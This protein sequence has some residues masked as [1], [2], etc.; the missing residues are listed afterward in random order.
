MSRKRMTKTQSQRWHTK[1]NLRDRYGIFCNR[2]VYFYLLDSIKN[3]QSE[4][5]LKQSN[6]RYLYKVYL[7]LSECVD[8]RTRICVPLEEN[9][10]IKIYVVYD[11]LRKELVTALPWFA[12]DAELLQDYYDNHQYERI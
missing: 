6:T 12:T 3:G 10:T 5:L 7:P 8:K 11:K 9:D 4:V 2:D 1:W